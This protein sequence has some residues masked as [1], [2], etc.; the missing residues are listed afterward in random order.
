MH[1]EYD[2]LWSCLNIKPSKW[3]LN[4]LKMLRKADINDEK[5][6]GDFDPTEIQD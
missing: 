1:S 3:T 6:G 5:A 4:P 2:T